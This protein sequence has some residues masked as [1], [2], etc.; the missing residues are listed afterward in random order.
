MQRDFYC[1]FTESLLQSDGRQRQIGCLAFVSF[2]GRDHRRIK[3]Q[4]LLRTPVDDLPVYGKGLF[5]QLRRNRHALNADF[6]FIADAHILPKS[7]LDIA[8]SPLRAVNVGGGIGRTEPVAKVCENAKGDGIVGAELDVICDLHLPGSEISPVA[9]HLLSV[10]EEQGFIADDAEMQ[11]H[12]FI[13]RCQR[14][15]NFFSIPPFDKR[16]LFR[17]RAGIFV[18]PI[19]RHGDLIPICIIK[20]RQLITFQQIFLRTER[21]RAVGQSRNLPGAIESAS[22]LKS[23]QVIAGPARQRNCD[24]FFGRHSGNVTGSLF[25]R[26]KRRHGS[27]G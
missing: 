16:L 3:G 20:L 26:I 25:G 14:N 15:L 24:L 4:S 2:H 23:G 17:P 12:R 11:D 5:L 10:D 22:L 8:Y 18:I 9:A 13:L 21:L 7:S 27:R 1:S 6:F 19:Q